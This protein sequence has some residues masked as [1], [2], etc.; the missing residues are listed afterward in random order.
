MNYANH[1]E[2]EEKGLAME[3]SSPQ[4]LLSVWEW[5]DVSTGR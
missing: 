2:G 3:L 5:A 4:G 1:E